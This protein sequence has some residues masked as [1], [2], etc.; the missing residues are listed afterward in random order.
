MSDYTVT[1]RRI[2]KERNYQ[3]KTTYA[4][5]GVSSNIQILTT[6]HTYPATQ[7][8]LRGYD[9]G[10]RD[11]HSLKGLVRKLAKSSDQLLCTVLWQQ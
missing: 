4:T 7:H 8:L 6:I 5:I 2:T 11:N 3:T 9:K 10:T 1:Q